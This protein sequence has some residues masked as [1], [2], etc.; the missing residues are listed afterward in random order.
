LYRPDEIASGRPSPDGGPDR[1]HPMHKIVNEFRRQ[2]GTIMLDLDR[3]NEV[4]G[5]TFLEALLDSEPNRLGAGFRERLLR[6]TAG[7]P[8]FSVEMLRTMQER[9]DLLQDRDNHWVEGPDLAWAKLPV[10]IE[11]VIEERIQ[12]LEAELKETLTVASVEGEDFT[13][14]VVARVREVAERE[15]VRQLSRELDKKHHLVGEQGIEQLG[16]RK[17][18]HFRFRHILFQQ[19]IYNKLSDVE[20]QILHQ[21]VGETLESLYGERVDE[22]APQ[23]ALHFSEAGESEKAVK[24][25]LQA[26]DRARSLYANEEA[27]SHYERALIFL[28][29]QSDDERAARTLMKL[30]LTYHNAFAFRRARQA[31]QEGFAFWQRA[32]SAPPRAQPGEAPHPLRVDWRED[33]TTLDPAL[34]DETH[35]SAVIDQLFSGLVELSPQMEIEPHLAQSWDILDGGR[36]YV[37]HLRDDVRWSDGAPVTAEDFEYAWKR[38]LS[39]AAGS[40]IASLLYDIKGARAFNLGHLADAGRVG[41]KALGKFEL[42]VELEQ[43]ASYVLQLLAHTITYPVPRHVVERHGMAWTAPQNIVSN[44]PFRLECWQPGESIV[45]VRNSAYF[46]RSRGNVQRVELFLISDPSTR[47]QMYES[48]ELDVLS[49]YGL[50]GEMMENTLRRHAGEFIH[51]PSLFTRYVAFKVNK[52]PFDDRRIRRAFILAIDRETLVDVAM[53]HLDRTPAG[54]GFVPPG[55][56]GHSPEIGL[57]CDRQAARQLLATAGFPGGKD[58]PKVR[59]IAPRVTESVC[60]Y[61]QE[62]WRKSLGVT[63]EWATAGSADSDKLLDSGSYQLYFHGWMAD[64]A[65]PDNFLRM[66]WQASSGRWIGWRNEEY[67]QLLE[68]AREVM[69]QEERL[70]L[71]RRADRILMEEAPIMPLAYGRRRRLVKPWVR[72]API[73]VTGSYAWKDAIIEPH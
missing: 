11:G 43:P 3:A 18:F 14:Q 56:P 52:V 34:A 36:K 71:F 38:A 15:L 30:G 6:H 25:L 64:Y 19:H 41:V 27:I 50:S 54:G 59:L 69:N 23:L 31:Y 45:L 42:E 13:A 1:P 72:L 53:R 33:P 28:R 65:D 67:D 63:I 9:G 4:G 46:G 29:A 22:I 8:L 44:G 16:R 61:L 2:F 51:S 35:T 49:P 10:R 48:G 68:R 21:Q 40:D 24:Y 58:F 17:V 12:R 70:A 57:R 20:R 5:R 26:G 37:F 73:T 55:M 39:P 60:K 32:S 62:G 66:F 47:L 7:Q